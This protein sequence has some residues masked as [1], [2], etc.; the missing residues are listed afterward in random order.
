MTDTGI[1]DDAAFKADIGGTRAALARAG[2]GVGGYYYGETFY[3]WGGFDQGGE[4]DG[5]LELYV[6]IDMKK[7]IGL[8][9]AVLLRQRLSDPRQLDHRRQYRLADAGLQS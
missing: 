7:A 6:N 5:V 4:Y 8:E 1:P 2:I 3:N 9:R